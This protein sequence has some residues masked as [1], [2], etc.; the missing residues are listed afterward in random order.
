MGNIRTKEIK[1]IAFD[2]RSKHGDKF[3]DDF[4]KNKHALR[5]LGIVS[6]KNARNKI[7]GYITRIANHG[8]KAE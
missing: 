5:E 2:L 6:E 7:A 1:K 3:S 4:E 8:K